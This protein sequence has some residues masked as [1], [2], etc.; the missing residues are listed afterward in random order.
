MNGRITLILADDHAMVRKGLTAFLATAQDIEVLGVA[1]NGAE[2]VAAAIQH[3]PDVVL[4]DLFMP[5]QPAIETVRHISMPV[6]AARS[7]W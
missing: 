3:T 5:D 2:A 1:S 6:P 7:S 4:L